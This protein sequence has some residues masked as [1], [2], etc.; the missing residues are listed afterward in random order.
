MDGPLD[1]A[2]VEAVRAGYDF[3][4]PALEIGALVNGEA[5]PGVPVRI[6]LAMT[7]RHG[8]VAGATG[9]GKTRTLQVLAEQLAA[10]G[11]P[12]FAADMKG[13]LT[14]VAT[15]GSSSEK[16]LARTRGIG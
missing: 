7:N 5:V 8:L 6:P 13:D 11:V 9:T 1:E 2:A 12:V 16:L 10:A 15:P 14:G 3:D 4:G